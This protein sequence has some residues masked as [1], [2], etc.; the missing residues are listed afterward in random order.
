MN[1]SLIKPHPDTERMTVRELHQGLEEIENRLEFGKEHGAEELFLT[2][3]ILE[4]R[5]V[6]AELGRRN[7]QGNAFPLSS[8]L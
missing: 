2:W 1:D 5:M 4:R 8:P 3:L 7:G 6:L